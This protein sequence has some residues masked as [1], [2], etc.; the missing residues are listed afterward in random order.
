MSRYTPEEKW[1]RIKNPQTVDDYRLVIS[2]D[3][4]LTFDEGVEI[5]NGITAAAYPLVVGGTK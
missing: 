2:V 5:V 4:L 1:A 3:E